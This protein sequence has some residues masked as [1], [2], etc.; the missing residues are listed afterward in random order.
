[1]GNCRSQDD[2]NGKRN[3]VQQPTGVESEDEQ[4]ASLLSG[5]LLG[6]L[7]VKTL[8]DRP[9]GRELQYLWQTFAA[10]YWQR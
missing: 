1:M 3:N 2:S 10:E 9:D 4:E 8:L 6:E 7:G 5:T